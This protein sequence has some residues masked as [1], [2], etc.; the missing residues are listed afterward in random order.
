[1]SALSTQQTGQNNTLFKKYIALP[2]D[3]GAWVFLLSPLLIGIWAGRTFTLASFVLALA[4][5][6]T[7]LLRQPLSIIA[8]I[9]SRR[10]AR[11]ELPS[12]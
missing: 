4:A 3:H 10:R 7:F 1:M 12:A 6:F 9:L 5:L 11:T 2:Q 8:K